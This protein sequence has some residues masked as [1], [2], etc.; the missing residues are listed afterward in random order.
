LL[1]LQLHEKLKLLDYEEKLCRPKDITP[2]PRTHFSVPSSNA[3][4]QFQHFME[5]VKFLMKECKR[6]FATD[7]WDDPN[8]IANKVMLELKEMGFDMDF[9]AIKLKQG[10]G[11]PVVRVLLFLA[12]HAM[13]LS[14]FVYTKPQYVEEEF[15][16][17]AEVDDDAEM[18]AEIEEAGVDSEEEEEVLYSELVQK[19]REDE[20]DAAQTAV[21]EATVDPIAWKT[22]LV[23][24]A[25]RLKIKPSVSSRQWRAH[26]EQTKKH[27]AVLAELFPDAQRALQKISSDLSSTLERVTSKEKYLNSTFHHLSEEYRTIRSRQDEV[28]SGFQTSSQSV[29]DLT[30]ELATVSDSLDEVKSQMEDRGSSMTDT[31]P[32]V[33]IQQALT[34][35]RTEIKTME[36]RIGVVGHTLMQSKLRTKPAGNSDDPLRDESTEFDISGDEDDVTY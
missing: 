20:E 3:S 23:R 17:E 29:S 35:L 36:L 32:L 4:V 30:N 14:G 16:E 27:E 26:Y 13:G 1:G 9:P 25:P 12:D 18:P 33:R 7:K 11:E 6:E 15:A 28:T 10:S 19:R 21:L 2:F 31:S 34:N 22:E 24:V 8:T 5:L